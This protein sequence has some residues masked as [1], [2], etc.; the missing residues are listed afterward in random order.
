M[1]INKK[2]TFIAKYVKVVFVSTLFNRY[3][4]SS[5]QKPLKH[6]AV[7]KNWLCKEGEIYAVEYD[8]C[9]VLPNTLKLKGMNCLLL[10]IIITYLPRTTPF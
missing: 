5:Q 7:T 1:K 3:V 9:L 4:C 8:T 6:E 10:Y 2:Q